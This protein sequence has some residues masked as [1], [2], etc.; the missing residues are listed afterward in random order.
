MIQSQS[1]AVISILGERHLLNVPS[2]KTVSTMFSNTIYNA[3]VNESLDAEV[4][5]R[6]FLSAFSL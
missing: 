3:L 4:F 2:V 5:I 1:E 6:D